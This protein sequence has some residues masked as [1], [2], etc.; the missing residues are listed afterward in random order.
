MRTHCECVHKLFRLCVCVC[1]CAFVSSGEHEF[2]HKYD[3][4]KHEIY[5]YV[6]KSESGRRSNKTLWILQSD[7]RMKRESVILKEM[8]GAKK[9]NRVRKMIKAKEYRMPA[10]RSKTLHTIKI[11]RT[12]TA[13]KCER[14]QK[15]SNEFMIRYAVIFNP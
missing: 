2:L 5:I 3:K 9:E 11:K 6:T 14:L 12:S 15:H 4:K 10:K 7:Q 13:T 1:V 8:R